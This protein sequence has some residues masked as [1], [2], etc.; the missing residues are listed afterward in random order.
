MRG[1]ETHY[2][3][4]GDAHIAYQVLGHGPIDIVFVQG[5]ISN[6]EVQWEEPGLAHL[7]SRLAGFGRLILFDKRGSGLSDRVPEMPN[8]ET[9]MDDVRAVMDAARSRQAVLIGAS[10]GGPMSILFAATYP[11]RT[12]ALVLY[13]AYAHFQSWV[14]THEQVQAFIAA[15]DRD[16]GTGASL[17][18]FA[19][20]MLGNPHFRTW[21]A[22]FERLGATPAAA[23]A[24]ARMNSEIDVRSVLPA[25]RV[26]TLVVHRRQDARVNVGAGRYLAA[27]IAGAQYVELEGIDHPIWVGDTDR[28]VDEIET[29]LT[30]ARPSASVQRVLS[31]VLVAD[32]ADAARLVAGAGDRVWLDRFHN[33]RQR[34]AEQVG[35]FKGRE[36]E[37]GRAGVLALFDGPTRAVHC[38]IAIREAAAALG[39][40]VRSGVNT[41]E[42]EIDGEVTA[43]IAL[44][45]AARIAAAARPGDVLVSGTV[46]DLA[47]GARLRFSERGECALEGMAERIRLLAVM[48]H[49]DHAAPS[50]AP[51]APP[52]LRM[53]SPRERE[54]LGWV[55]EGLTNPAIAERLALSEHTVKRHVANILLKLDLPS[56]S[57][58]A[59]LR[60]QAMR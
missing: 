48:D 47:V 12:R 16:W 18:H 26:P 33:F 39:L 45:V 3:R 49:D 1:A 55:A 56:R 36:L 29:F 35:R 54:I 51:L 14:Q 13:G 22:R 28:I 58:A 37:P 8:M 24:L 25:V 20:G 43:G 15:A 53:L 57:A 17:K 44:H 7:L 41:G 5:F 59:A 38:A 32:I 50:T 21:W 40:E 34:V 9:R 30:G 46:R 27:H 42:I 31:T 60:A 52:A 10:E 2:A 11:H 19:P 4:S 23:M 6:L